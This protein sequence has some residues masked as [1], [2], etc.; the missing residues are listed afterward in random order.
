MLLV[1]DILI[2]EYPHYRVEYLVEVRESLL[3]LLKLN[4]LTWRFWTRVNELWNQR[5]ILVGVT[6]NNIFEA[7]KFLLGAMYL[8]GNNREAEK[9]VKM[10]VQEAAEK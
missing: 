4:H 9:L 2:R 3:R 8:E 6:H 7:L 10:V 5:Q 1:N